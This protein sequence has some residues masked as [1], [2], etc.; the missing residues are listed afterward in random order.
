[1]LKAK[2]PVVPGYFG[3]DQNPELLKSEALKIEYPVLIKAVKGGGGKGMRIVERPEEFMEMLESA[4]R[5]ALKSFGDDRVLVE[6]YII[7]PRH[8]EVQVFGDQLGNYVYLFERD[9]SV[10]RRHQKIIEEAPAVSL[11]PHS[12][13]LNKKGKAI[14]EYTILTVFNSSFKPHLSPEKQKSFGEKAVAAAKAVSY[15]GA[16][17]VEFILDE[18]TGKFFFMEMNTRLQVKGSSSSLSLSASISFSFP[19]LLSLSSSPTLSFLSFFLSLFSTLSL[20]I[21]ITS[22]SM[23]HFCGAHSL[24]HFSTSNGPRLNILSQR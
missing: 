19:F 22:R 10:Q 4:K 2:V 15:C 16:G 7:R 12:S 24:L 20:S 8:V 6:K 14:S 3:D 18:D 5:E 23:S 17:T 1:M 21:P 11:P 13:F 9:C